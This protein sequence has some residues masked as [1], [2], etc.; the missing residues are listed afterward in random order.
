MIKMGYP[1]KTPTLRTML[2]FL[3]L[4][5]FIQDGKAQSEYLGLKPPGNDPVLFAPSIVNTD[6]IEINAVFNTSFTEVFFTRIVANRFVIHHSERIN[7]VWSSPSPIE[8]YA[9]K[10]SESVAIDPSISQDG[11]TMFF[12]GIA[13]EDSLKNPKPD[14]YRSE[15][16]DG[17][18][19]LATK[20]DFPVS[21][22][23]YVE[24]YPVV[25]ADGSLYFTSDRPGGYGKRD[26]YRAQHLGNG[27]FEKPVNIGPS[28]NSVE[29]ERS[30]FVSPDE[31]YLITGKQKGFAIS[32]KKDGNWQTSSYFEVGKKEDGNWIYY[33]PYMSPD[34]K[35]FFFSRRRNRPDV[36]GWDGVVAGEVYWMDASE[37]LNAHR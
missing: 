17:V 23:A 30:T 25:V 13:P 20:V 1:Y 10:I 18:W 3:L 19:Q 24:S 22:E 8:M 37:I 16:I 15:K 7:G 2:G 31:R 36:N 33:C 34:N 21:T 12:L 6:S 14:I 28:V 29:G 9:D 26:I 11:R 35:Y 27:R 4:I 32:F 5:A